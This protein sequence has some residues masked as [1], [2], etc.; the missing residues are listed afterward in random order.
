MHE[1]TYVQD[2]P[3]LPTGEYLTTYQARA[4]R[5]PKRPPSGFAAAEERG[6][7]TGCGDRVTRTCY[8]DRDTFKLYRRDA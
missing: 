6:H 2:H 7:C 3:P 1:H 4:N 8:L 5:L